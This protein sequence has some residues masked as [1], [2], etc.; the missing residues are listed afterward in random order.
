MMMNK[1]SNITMKGIYV[2]LPP[3]SVRNSGLILLNKNTATMKVDI[4]N[5]HTYFMYFCSFLE[6]EHIE[7]LKDVITS[8]E[9]D[10]N[11]FP[12]K[13][14]SALL[15]TITVNATQLTR[16]MK[17]IEYLIS[18]SSAEILEDITNN[19]VIY[20]NLDLVKMIALQ[21]PTL[22]DNMF[23]NCIRCGLNSCHHCFEV[24][25]YLSKSCKDINSLD[26]KGDTAFHNIGGICKLQTEIIKILLCGGADINKV[27]SKNKIPIMQFYEEDI[28]SRRSLEKLFKEGANINYCDPSGDNMLRMAI[29]KND[30]EMIKLL[31]S[32]NVEIKD[33]VEY[34][35]KILKNGLIHLFDKRK[36]NK[37]YC[38]DINTAECIICTAKLIG[39]CTGIEIFLCGHIFHKSCLK[40]LQSS[41]ICPVCRQYIKEPEEREESREYEEFANT[42]DENS[43]E[44]SDE[45]FLYELDE[46]SGR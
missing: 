18:V 37:I 7:L 31:V 3:L 9:I 17:I 40:R 33:A 2:V 6:D 43:D 25:N 39:Q 24:I 8:F 41:N 10:V 27:N 29:R 12:K 26:Y 28:L 36:L 22:I 14:C 19:R 38:D 30:C 45:E 1:S 21:R 23:S 11:Q 15:K 32:M 34:A 44:N 13:G 5:E 16:K 42:E 20:S 35:N 4:N 46:D